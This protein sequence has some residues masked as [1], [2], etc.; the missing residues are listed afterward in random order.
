MTEQNGHNRTIGLES[1]GQLE[2]PGL[3]F[4]GRAVLYAHEVAAKLRCDVRHVYD[5]VDAGKIRAI[6]IGGCSLSER[7]Y[8]RIPV[9]AWDAFVRENTL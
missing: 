1:A 6:N 7:R 3:S 9:E 2:F 5:L 4:T 8:L